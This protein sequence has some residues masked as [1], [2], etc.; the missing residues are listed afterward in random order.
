MFGASSALELSVV[1]DCPDI[2]T[3]GAGP[4][5]ILNGSVTSPAIGFVSEAPKRLVPGPGHPGGLERL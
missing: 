3:G 2:Q 1:G 5:D 4:G